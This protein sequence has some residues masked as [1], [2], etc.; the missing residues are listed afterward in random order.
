MAHTARQY[1]NIRYSALKN[2]FHRTWAPHLQEIKD[3]LM[4]WNGRHLTGT[5]ATEINDGDKKQSSIYDDVPQQALGV[6]AGGMQS[7]LT[8]PARPWFRLATPDSD[9]NAYPPVKMWL[10]QVEELMRHTFNKSNVYNSTHEIYKELA[11]FGTAACL[12]EEDLEN[13]IHCK[14]FTAGQY[15]LDTDSKRRV[16]TFVRRFFLT[17]RQMVDTFGR[18]QVSVAVK[19]NWDND[20]MEVRHAVIQFIEPNDND[21]VKLDGFKK[22]WRS[23][24]YEPGAPGDEFL[25]VGGYDEF[26]V[27]APRWET[28]AEDVYGHSLGMRMLPDIKML[29]DL[30][31]KYL[32]ALHKQI[33]PPLV[34]PSGMKTE[35]ISSIPGGV[36]YEIGA[37]DSPG[38]RPLHDV[39]VRLDYVDQK[40]QQ[41]QQAIRGGFF[42]QLFMMLANLDRTQMTATEVA[43]RH[44]EKLIMLG[45]VL[46]QLHT[47]LLDKL[48]D[49]TFGIMLRNGALPEAPPEIAGVDLKVQ[50]ISILAQAQKM[51]GTTGIEQTMAFA[52]NMAAVNPQ[53]LDKVNFDRTLEVYADFTGIPPDLL[54]TDEA[55]AMIRQQRQQA[56]AAQQAAV[57]AESVSASAETLSKADVGGN[58]ALTALLGGLGGGRGY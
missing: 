14:V 22:P 37:T 28:V 52:G 53:V 6:L 26:P 38:L 23:V 19:S 21:R 36:T 35:A 43:E 56:M 9:L 7:G 39:G 17:T 10:Y 50:Y 31:K 42:N 51:V 57:A 45:P 27:L 13:V 48:I 41:V 25:R 20:A 58:N 33:S 46:E 15:F 54:N 18:D 12:V 11:G 30:Q 24:Y 29:Y 40:I 44:E 34:A 16:N 2:E 55:V 4:P 49:R 5:D 1:Y 8:S 32:I 47:E 3:N